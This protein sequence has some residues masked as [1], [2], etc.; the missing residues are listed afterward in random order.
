MCRNVCALKNSSSGEFAQAGRHINNHPN[1]N[2]HGKEKGREEGKEA[3]LVCLKKKPA[4]AGFFFFCYSASY[5]QSLPLFL[6]KSI[7]G[8]S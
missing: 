6:K 3:P 8:F 7:C 1:R 2:H 4:L 5:V